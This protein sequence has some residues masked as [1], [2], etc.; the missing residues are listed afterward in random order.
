MT[1]KINAEMVRR[2][3]TEKPKTNAQIA[4]EL[5]V[6][7]S[8]PKRHLDK[9]ATDGLAK[10]TPEGWIRAEGREA[11]AEKPVVALHDI[12]AMIVNAVEEE[13][14]DRIFHPEEFA[15]ITGMPSRENA[16]D[17]AYVHRSI[18]AEILH[19]MHV[20]T[21]DTL[22]RNEI[23]DEAVDYDELEQNIKRIELHAKAA[24]YLMAYAEAIGDQE[25]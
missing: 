10:K 5:G 8:S 2:T 6:A 21:P 25:V 17:S 19:A 12:T 1:S 7:R 18:M 3:L 9:L 24:K 23:R 11:R 16:E 15:D 4:K 20:A 13:I 14:E 22:Y